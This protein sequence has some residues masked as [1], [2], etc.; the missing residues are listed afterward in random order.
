[1][2]NTL[3]FVMALM[4]LPSE[5]VA[6]IATFL[7]RS[8]LLD[9]RMASRS[10]RQASERTFLESYFTRRVHL[11]TSSSLRRLLDICR[12]SHLVKRLETIQILQPDNGISSEGAFVDWYGPPGNIDW[13]AWIHDSQAIKDDDTTLHEIFRCLKRS[14]V[15]PEILVQ[16]SAR[17]YENRPCGFQAYIKPY[18]HNDRHGVRENIQLFRHYLCDIASYGLANAIS[19]SS[20]PLKILVLKDICDPTLSCQHTDAD[21]QQRYSTSFLAALANMTSLESI[22]LLFSKDPSDGSDPEPLLAIVEALKPLPLSAIQLRHVS[23]SPETFVALLSQHESTLRQISFEDVGIV[24][25]DLLWTWEQPVH[26]MRSMAQLQQVNLKY[27][28]ETSNERTIS[29]VEDVHGRT[30][31]SFKEGKDT[32]VQGI[33]RLINEVNFDNIYYVGEHRD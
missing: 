28:C 30:S 13:E 18:K 20:I 11:Y 16:S 4:Y 3:L 10:Y 29:C 1:M 15:T 19:G 6:T 31:W 22:S 9:F 32:I 26:Q 27:L 2:H 24:D 33:T 25:E 14:N 17:P 23:G 12:A 5:M 21:V 8:T 7:D